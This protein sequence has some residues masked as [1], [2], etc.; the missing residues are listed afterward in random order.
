MSEIIN[1]GGEH[2]V[3]L[4]E[5]QGIYSLT[6]CYKGYSQW[7]KQKISKTEYSDKD[8]PVKVV[9]GNKET[10]VKALTELLNA[11]SIPF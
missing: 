6:A 4:E 9:L 1:T 3:K 10:A 11:I 2:G 7:G 5:Y 8:R